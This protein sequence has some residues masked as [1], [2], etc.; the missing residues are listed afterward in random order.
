MRCGIEMC[1]WVIA[2]FTASNKKVKLFDVMQGNI[3]CVV[4]ASSSDGMNL[5]DSLLQ[6]R[7]SR[8]RRGD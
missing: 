2:E 5:Q 6:K 8:P 1:A 3:V 7:L 4:V